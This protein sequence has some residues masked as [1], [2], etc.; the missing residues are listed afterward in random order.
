[1]STVQLQSLWSVTAPS[2]PE[3]GA[4]SSAQRA[5]AVVIGAGYTG[6]SAALHLAE[7]GRDVLVLEAAEIG[8]RASGV[9]GGQV[10]PGVKQDPDAL[11][12]L[13]GPYTGGRLVATAAAGP[14]LVF[15]LIERHGIQCEA[16]RSGWIQ[17][18]TSEAALGQL[19]RRAEQWWRRGAA[20][21]LLSRREV[22]QLTGSARYCGALLDRR[23]GTVQPLAYVRGLAQAV[24]R[25]GG[26]IRTHSPAV[27]LTRMAGAWSV[28]TPLGSASAPVIIIA[29]NAYTGLLTEQ[30]RRT[31]ISVP[32]FQV[33]TAPLPAA[34][35]RTILPDGQAASDTWHLLRYF[36]L[37]AGGR[38]VLG[39]RGTFAP[40][41]TLHDVRYHYRAVHEIY[42]QLV[43]V[44]FEYHWGGLVAMTR[45]HLPHLHELAPGL[46]AG[47][48]Y[49]GRGVAMATVMGRLLARRA[50]GAT[51]ME[52]G[53]PVTPVLPLPFHRLSG[54]AARAAIQYLRCVDG[55]ARLRARRSAR[56]PFRM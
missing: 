12:A 32:S 28:D 38:L 23:G 44:P 21:E 48:G 19:A 27:R 25:A 33:A 41:P 45:D 54:M 31:V 6:L 5:H 30:L 39:S 22:L 37:D 20:V 35:R 2:G 11:E 47:L 26:R 10:I 50:L 52:L 29:T 46:L 14:D 4:L 36:R 3:C 53:F 42:P 1:M 15:E 7:A 43:G 24:L 34:L 18:A 55:V 16:T 49:N 8:E 9:N 17:P 56:V 40:A 51:V 13:L